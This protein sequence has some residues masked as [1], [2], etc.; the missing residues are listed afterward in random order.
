M[1]PNQEASDAEQQ[2]KSL[3]V[4][5]VRSGVPIATKG[6]LKLM[7]KDEVWLEGQAD[8]RS[9]EVYSD[10]EKL[11]YTETTVTFRT[12]PEDRG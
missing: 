5:E 4:N 8:M 11:L 1:T 12:P 6:C 2:E 9:Q 10:D 7:Y 3:V